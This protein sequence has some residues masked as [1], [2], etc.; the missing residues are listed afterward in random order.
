M[1]NYTCLQAKRSVQTHLAAL[2]YCLQLA[3][4]VEGPLGRH[5]SPDGIRTDVYQLSSSACP[6]HQEVDHPTPLKLTCL[7]QVV[8]ILQRPPAAVGPLELALPLRRTAPQHLTTNTAVPFSNFISK[9]VLATFQLSKDG[10][11]LYRHSPLHQWQGS[12]QFI[13]L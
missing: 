9:L 13:D 10:Q 2:Q 6:V 1:N 7:P 4:F 12:H 3:A 8:A 11:R 5:N